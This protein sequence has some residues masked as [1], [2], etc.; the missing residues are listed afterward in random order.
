MRTTRLLQCAL[1]AALPSWTAALRADDAVK[2]AEPSGLERELRANIAQ[3][4]AAYLKGDREAFL[5]YLADGCLFVGV[6]GVETVAEKA[7][8][9]KAAQGETVTLEMASGMRVQ[10]HGGTAIAAYLQHE[11]HAYGHQ[12]FTAERGIVDTYVRKGDRWLLA[13]HAEIRTNP[14]RAVAKVDPA[15]YKQYLGQYEW[16]PGFVDTLTLKGD[17]LMAR[18]TGEDEAE[19]LPEDATS[20]FIT[21]DSDDGVTTFV[22]GPSGAVTHYV[23]RAGGQEVVARKIK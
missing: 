22:K 11:K 15:V 8:R 1:L 13:S 18:L 21:E 20:F 4:N 14:K 6:N 23:Y 19:L 10:E 12:S 17:R 7:E 2:A 16:G 3:R 5:P 9:L